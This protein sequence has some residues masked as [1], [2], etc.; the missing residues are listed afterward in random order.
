VALAAM[1]REIDWQD[2]DAIAALAGECDIT[3]D[4]DKVWL[5]GRDVSQ[6]IR[7][8][9]VG[10][11]IHHVADHPGVRQ[12]LV[13]LQRQYARGRNVVTEGRDQGSVAFPH[14][15]CKIFLT[16]SPEERARRRL[17]DFQA[18]GEAA[19]FNEVLAQQSDRDRRDES[20]PVGALKKAP[21]AATILT[22]GLSQEQVVD[23]IETLVRKCMGEAC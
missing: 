19:S 18:R 21:D 23:K 20:R 7:A 4:G 17:A 2:S 16:A 22:D 13:Q 6:A 3:L 10:Q 1:E 11:V 12:R 14:A 9:Q 15:E 8:P 5:N